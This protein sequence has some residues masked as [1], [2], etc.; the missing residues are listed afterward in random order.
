LSAWFD[1][2]VGSG[3]RRLCGTRDQ[4][5]IFSSSAKGA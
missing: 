5:V 4:R 1:G 3:L 2:G